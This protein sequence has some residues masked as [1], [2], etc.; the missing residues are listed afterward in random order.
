MNDFDEA[1]AEPF[2]LL[3][4]GGG[5]VG[6][7]VA[8]F[9]ARAG[10]RTAL[11]ERHDFGSGT[12]GA[13]TEL[14]HGG[15][16][17]LFRLKLR[18]VRQSNEYARRIHA[19]ARHLTRPVPIIV[20]CY[21]DGSFSFFA[22]RLIMR[23][24]ESYNRRYKHAP[25]AARLTPEQIVAEIPGIRRDHLL[26]GVKYY[27]WWIDSTRLCV[28]NALWAAEHGAQ[29]R[30]HAEV[31]DLKPRDGGGFVVTVDD[32]RTGR[33][34]TRQARIVVNA[35]G[36]WTDRLCKL[37]GASDRTRIRPTRG[38]HIF[39]P[40]IADVGLMVPFVDGRFGVVVPRYE[41]SMVGTT[42][43]DYY[44]DLDQMQTTPDEVGYLLQGVQRVLPGVRREDVI[45]TK[46]GVRP[47][48]FQFGKN[49]DK[50]SRD[51]R[52]ED[53]PTRPGLISV[54]GGKLATHTRMAE[55][56]LKYVG[57]MLGRGRIEVPSDYRLPGA[58]DEALDDFVA[59]TVPEMVKEFEITASEVAVLARRHGTK[60]REVLERIGENR[61]L[62]ED[63]CADD[64]KTLCEPVLAAE[65]VQAAD[66][67]WALTDGDVARRTGC[68]VGVRRPP[69]WPARV[70]ALLA[71]TSAAGSCQRG[72]TT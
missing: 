53:H 17:Y 38:A 52:V 27:E 62:R 14:I 72:A 21:K 47:T 19:S 55:D 29:V 40:K 48:I 23:M 44:G 3:V 12:T 33:R 25:P 24:Y 64:G 54:Y 8:M 1:K 13:S 66:C 51:H 22:L 37:A 67:Q 71:Q 58:P 5:C 2:D 42:D 15:L 7:A 56:V 26:G 68:S 6:T 10:L 63:V 18:I 49:E 61:A 36:P 20:P 60:L 9:A 65:V 46:A 28:A 11:C 69:K 32:R 50:V 31:V 41:T 57:A 4:I 30:N 43:D 70:T 45:D 39:L 16:Q 35:T 59:R 34:L